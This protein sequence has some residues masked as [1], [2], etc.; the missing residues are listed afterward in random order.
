[1]RLPLSLL[2]FALPRPC[3]DVATTPI[4]SFAFHTGNEPKIPVYYGKGEDRQILVFCMHV[5]ADRHDYKEIP[6][7]ILMVFDDSDLESPPST[8]EKPTP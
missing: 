8:G 4:P 2:I 1:M 7:H 5:A 3:A 6:V